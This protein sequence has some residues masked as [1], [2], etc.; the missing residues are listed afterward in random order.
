MLLSALIMFAT[1][2]L[3]SASTMSATSDLS[4]HY[5]SNCCLSH[6]FKAACWWI[7]N[8]CFSGS[9]LSGDVHQVI[10]EGLLG[11]E[12]GGGGQEQLPGDQHR[13]QGVPHNV[14]TEQHSLN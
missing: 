7:S 6:L 14:P 3:L 8:V 1:T 9:Y 4:L 10:E 12:G 13:G 5:V 11:G 2:A